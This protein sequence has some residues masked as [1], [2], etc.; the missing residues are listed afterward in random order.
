MQYRNND[1]SGGAATAI[2]SNAYYNNG[3]ITASGSRPVY[4]CSTSGAVTSMGSHGAV[5]AVSVWSAAIQL[6]LSDIW[7]GGCFTSV[8]V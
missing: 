7:D 2:F 5:P 8:T 3:S 6:S 4:Q 1:T